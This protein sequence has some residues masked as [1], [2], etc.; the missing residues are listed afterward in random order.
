MTAAD[1]VRDWKRRA[2][3]SPSTG[4]NIWVL[5]VAARRRPRRRP[6]VGLARL[7]DVLVRLAARARRAAGAA[8]VSCSSTSS[9]SGSPTSPTFGTAC[10][11]RPTSWKASR[12]HSGSTGLRSSRTTWATPWVASSWRAAS[13]ARCRSRSPAGC[14]T[15]GSIYIDMAH[16]TTGQELLLSLPDA[17]TDLVR[18]DGYRAGLAGTFSPKSNV[19]DDELEAQWLLAARD[20]GNTLLPRTIRY[21]E[22]RRAEERRFT[23][24][25]E[26]HPVAA[27]RR[28][29]R[30]RPDRGRRDDRDVARRRGPTS[31]SRCSTASAT[32]RCSKRPSASRP[33]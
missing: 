3:G 10:D 27:R 8:G 16:L 14:S 7:P 22:D 5:D 33:P 30:G 31:T 2:G 21:I 25:I 9:A 12:P 18:A 1:D 6:V 32:T 19:P 11:C 13:K 17:P 29:G 20:D 26:A 24:A 4:A 28:V 15:N 23:G